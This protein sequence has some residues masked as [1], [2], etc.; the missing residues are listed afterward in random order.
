[1]LKVILI[2]KLGEYK[3][4]IVKSIH[5]KRVNVEEIESGNSCCFHIK[6]ID[7][8]LPI[9]KEHIRKGMVLLEKNSDQKCYKEFDAMVKILHTPALIK[10]KYQSVIHIGVVRQTAQIVEIKEKDL[11][12]T[13]DSALVKFRFICSPEYIHEGAEF[14]FREGRTS[15]MGQIVKLY[16]FS[17]KEVKVK[18]KGTENVKGKDADDKENPKKTK[19]Y[20][21]YN[22]D[23][24]TDSSEITIKKFKEMTINDKDK[25]NQ[26]K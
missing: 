25:E 1:M 20:K 26:E 22:K 18:T 16:P 21:N 23:K 5:F 10:V 13:G 9:K 19:E 11:L 6:S 8:K 14:L 2:L 17:N 3:Q 24:D 7:S 4:V 12:K 15:G